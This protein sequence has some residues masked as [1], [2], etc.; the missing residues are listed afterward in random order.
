MS[1]NRADL[2]P[3]PINYAPEKNIIFKNTCPTLSECWNEINIAPPQ[4]SESLKM[5]VKSS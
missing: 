2:I 1:S 4:D 3:I 5:A